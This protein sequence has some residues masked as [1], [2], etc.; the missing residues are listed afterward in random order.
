MNISAK[1]AALR[2]SCC[3]GEFFEQHA[4]E[5]LDQRDG[6][7][8]AADEAE[9]HGDARD[10]EH[11]RQIGVADFGDA[12]AQHLDDHAL[13]VL[14]PGAMHLTQRRRRDG[15]IVELAEARR[16]SVQVRCSM[17]ARICVGRHARHFVAQA[18]K[19]VGHFRR[20]HVAARRDE[21]PRLDH[22]AAHVDGEDAEGA[23]VALPALEVAALDALREIALHEDLPEDQLHEQPAEMPDDA[24][25]AELH[26][27]R[28][29]AVLD[30]LADLDA[31]RGRARRANP[32][33]GSPSAVCRCRPT[34]IGVTCLWRTG[35]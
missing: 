17:I 5:F 35:C 33:G 25:V 1:R 3:V 18:G 15:L 11:R 6:V 32:T 10:G 8:A 20:Q 22:H 7:H 23:G 31:L 21:L 30:H 9:F 19:F 29:R 16:Q 12:G 28:A 26:P 13:A 27:Q 4:P 34:T 24:H 2:A 14:Q